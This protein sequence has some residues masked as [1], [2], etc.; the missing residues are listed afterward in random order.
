MFKIGPGLRA[1]ESFWEGS[2][3]VVGCSVLRQ[4]ALFGR[5]G[6]LQSA[7]CWD[8]KTPILIMLLC[9]V[10]VV[11]VNPVDSGDSCSST[12]GQYTRF[13]RGSWIRATDR[14]R[15]REKTRTKREE[16]RKIMET[17][18]DVEDLVDHDRVRGRWIMI[19]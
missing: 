15:C 16:R 11:F 7:G 18:A 3:V 10:R 9:G 12:E 6:G 17:L 19:V 5:R 14:R 1:N 13:R 2:T 8:E 4:V